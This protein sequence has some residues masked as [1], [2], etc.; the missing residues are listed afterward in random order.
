MGTVSYTS[1]ASTHLPVELHYCCAK[2]GKDVHTTRYMRLT[3]E[4]LQG[5]SFQYAQASARSRLSASAS[6]QIQAI[7]ANMENG[8]VPQYTSPTEVSLSTLSPLVCPSCGL[9]NWPRYTTMPVTTKPGW[10][11]P[12]LIAFPVVMLAAWLFT[13]DWQIHESNMPGWLLWAFVAAFFVY[14][15]LF[16]VLNPKLSKKALENPKLMEKLYH[17]VPNDEIYADLTPYD[18]GEIRLGSKAQRKGA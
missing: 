10:F 12:T 2:C 1:T 8:A 15:I 14:L 18:L 16:L 17:G 5:G 11:L 4:S 13:M 3:A 9:A 6:A 7:A